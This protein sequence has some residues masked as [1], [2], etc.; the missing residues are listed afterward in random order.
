MVLAIFYFLVL[1]TFLVVLRDN[2]FSTS[3][4]NK[5]SRNFIFFIRLK[6]KRELPMKKY[7]STTFVILALFLLQKSAV[8]QFEVSNVQARQL[9]YPAEFVEITYNVVSDEETVEIILE[10]SMNGGNS[11]DVPVV[12]VEGDV[13]PQIAPGNNKRILWNAGVDY[14]NQITNRMRARVTAD[15]R[16]AGDL[17]TFE[18][19]NGVN[20]IMVWIPP[21]EFMMGSEL[22]RD[23][24]PVHQ[25]TF[26]EGFWM[27]QYEVTQAQWE[28]V[29]GDNPSHYQGDE[30]PNYVD[31]D[32]LPI[33]NVS[34]YDVQEFE[35]RL[36][37]LYRLPSESEWEYSCRAGT[38]TDYYW[39]TFYANNRLELIDANAWYDVN[40]SLRTHTVGEKQPNPWNLYD[41]C[42]NVY[43]YCEDNYKE[44]YQGVPNDGRAW[45][46]FDGAPVIRGGGWN[47]HSPELLSGHRMFSAPDRCRPDIGFRLVREAD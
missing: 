47:W 46:S 29:M 19:A 27:S 38:Q 7:I 41:I 20:I 23:A 37:G 31:A 5:H 44:D 12:H 36:G 9:D 33:E 17:R 6:L 15:D 39:G 25:V 21:G 30:I 40:S 35:D 13:G 28:V 26:A 45:I 32:N 2:E 1:L 10:M 18:L 24:T 11:W 16:A 22:G 43:E 14:P 8:A 3:F 34:W 4:V 42:G